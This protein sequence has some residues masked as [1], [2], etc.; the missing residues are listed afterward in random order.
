MDKA[1]MAEALEKLQVLNEK[2]RSGVVLTEAE[3]SEFG[4]VLPFME[5]CL[6]IARDNG[7][8][9]DDIYNGCRFTL[10]S[11]HNVAA[12]DDTAAAYYTSVTEKFCTTPVR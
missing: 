9:S 12:G 2:R 8:L 4:V 7:M 3:R 10:K 11:W 5:E 1:L 6:E